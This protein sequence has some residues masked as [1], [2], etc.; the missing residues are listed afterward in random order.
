MKTPVSLEVRVAEVGGLV[1][2]LSTT[3]DGLFRYSEFLEIYEAPDSFASAAAALY[4]DPRQSLLH[5]EITGYAMQR[6]ALPQFVKLVVSVADLVEEERV[7]ERL[8]D[9][10]AFPPFNWGAKL[11]LNYQSA[12]VR[13]VLERL[14]ALSLLSESRRQY[15]RKSV[16]SGKARQDYLEMKE[17]GQIP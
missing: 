1:K 2:D 8:L 3:P 5:K 10:L 4:A 14:A 9:K 16:L 6:L 11:V 12:E 17:A 15:I 13:Q 7:P